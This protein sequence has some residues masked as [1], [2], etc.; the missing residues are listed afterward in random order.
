VQLYDLNS[1]YG[2]KDQLVALNQALKSAGI[3]PIADVVVNH[4]WVWLTK[5]VNHLAWV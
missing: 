1:H 5:R 3:S 4:R 2:N